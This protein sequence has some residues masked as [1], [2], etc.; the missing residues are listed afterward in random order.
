MFLPLRRDAY[1]PRSASS[2]CGSGSHSGI[3]ILNDFPIGQDP[4]HSSLPKQQVLDGLHLQMD[5]QV[6]RGRGLKEEARWPRVLLLQQL[7]DLW[8]GSEAYGPFLP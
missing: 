5:G 7:S 8:L 1:L 2:L 6:G 4:H 3:I